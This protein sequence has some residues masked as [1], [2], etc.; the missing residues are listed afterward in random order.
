MRKAIASMAVVFVC[1]VGLAAQT[2]VQMK[3]LP[4][5]VRRTVLTETKDAK[6]VNMVKERPR[7]VSRSS[8]SKPS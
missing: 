1:A 7:T 3:D 5:A 4:A 2:K 8:R 6:I